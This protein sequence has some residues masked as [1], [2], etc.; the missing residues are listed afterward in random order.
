MYAMNAPHH[1]FESFDDNANFPFDSSSLRPSGGNESSGWQ[2]KHHDRKF[3]RGQRSVS[4]LL[5]MV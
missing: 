2:G 5:L 3:F 4:S 1:L